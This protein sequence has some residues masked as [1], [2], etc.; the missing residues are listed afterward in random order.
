MDES[1]SAKKEAEHVSHDVI[2]DDTA[3]WKEKPNHATE[4]IG[5]YQVWLGHNEKQHEV[6]EAKHGELLEISALAKRKYE[7]HNSCN[8]NT[9]PINTQEVQNQGSQI[10]F[11]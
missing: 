6:S 10:T 4:Q 11:F 2:G 9:N 8:I 3:D 7:A 5:H 1:G